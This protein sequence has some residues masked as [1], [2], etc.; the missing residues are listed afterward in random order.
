LGDNDVQADPVDDGV[1]DHVEK[2]EA[3]CDF[4]GERKCVQDQDDPQRAA[5]SDA[6][7]SEYSASATIL[8]RFLAN[9]VI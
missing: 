1:A 3:R 9:Y 6:L 4:Q 2:R 5:R 8:H 7:R